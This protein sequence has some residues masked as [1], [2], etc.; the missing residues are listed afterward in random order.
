VALCSGVCVQAGKNFTVDDKADALDTNPG[1]GICASAGGT[2]TLRAAIMESNALAG[3]D[4]VIL[5]SGVYILT[6]GGSGEDMATLGDLDITDDVTVSGGGAGSTI[7]DGNGNVINDRVLHVVDSS[8]TATI[9]GVT[10]RNGGS[11]SYIYGGGIWADGEL[12]VSSSEIANNFGDGLY[13]RSNLTLTQSTVSGNT[14]HGIF[15]RGHTTVIDSTLQNNKG[16]GIHNRGGDLVVTNS[17]IRDNEKCGIYSDEGALLLENSTVSGNTQELDLDRGGGISNHGPAIVTN[18]IITDNTSAW[19]GGGIHNSSSLTVISSTICSNIGRY[20]GGIYSYRE[21]EITGSTVCSNTA[22]Y[23]GGGIFHSSSNRSAHLTNTTIS[24]NKAE[25]DGGGIASTTAT[26]YLN[27]VTL[28]NNVASGDGGGIYARGGG[29]VNVANSIIAGNIDTSSLTQHP[30]CSGTLISQGFNL[31]QNTTGCFIGGLT[32]GNIAS[33]DPILDPLMDNGGPTLTHALLPGSPAINAGNPAGC[34]D[35]V[36]NLL[37][38]DQRGRPRSGR[39][40]M[41]AYE[42]EQTTLGS[43]S[44]TASMPAAMPS[45]LLTYTITVENTGPVRISGVLVTDTLPTSVTYADQSLTATDGDYDYENGNV[46]WNGSLDPAGTVIITF[47]ATVS[48]VVPLGTSIANTA[49]ISGGGEIIS[50]TA[51]VFVGHR[52]YLPLMTKGGGQEF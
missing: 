43:T 19:N 11:A 18:S 33:I 30:D 15:A 37:L 49:I 50:R 21:L 39:C 26:P 27:N 38:K 45:G 24:G 46:M 3:A 6:I 16:N 10:I 7:I 36:S 20:G 9:R 12:V 42:Y 23:D 1:D 2:C 31:I 32:M 28:T 40:D 8:V 47:R 41:G 4:T 34:I 44:K 17:T 25:G 48:D 13:C 52:M 35:H 14:E 5:P 51:K 22:T 29:A